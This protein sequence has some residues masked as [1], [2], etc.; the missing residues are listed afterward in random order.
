MPL[1]L[2]W[3]SCLLRARDGHSQTD[4]AFTEVLENMARVVAAQRAVEPLNWAAP[5]CASMVK[6][7]S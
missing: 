3:L 5:F 2:A 4:S 7:R 1:Y 6:M